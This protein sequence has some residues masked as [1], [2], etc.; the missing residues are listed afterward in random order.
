MTITRTVDGKDLSFTLTRDELV[1]GYEELQLYYDMNNID[2]L[3]TLLGEAYLKTRFGVSMQF[4][5][6]R[7]PGMA[8]TMRVLMEDVGDSMIT[9][10]D[11]AMNIVLGKAWN[12]TD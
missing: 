10:R 11:E 9:A 7:L 5:R 2:A 6:D 8:K 4:A 3:I 1:S 12:K